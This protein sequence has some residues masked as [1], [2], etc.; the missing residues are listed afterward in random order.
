M[1]YPAFRSI[2]DLQFYHLSKGRGHHAHWWDNTDEPPG[3]IVLTP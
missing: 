1:R 2:V 3:K